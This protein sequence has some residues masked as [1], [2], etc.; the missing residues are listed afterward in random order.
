[1][2]FI[3]GVSNKEHTLYKVVVARDS[4][5]SQVN[6]VY[7]RDTEIA[8]VLVSAIPREVAAWTSSNLELVKRV[9]KFTNGLILASRSETVTTTKVF[10]VEVDE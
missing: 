1:M 10:E 8:S 9:A 6:F 4:H 2:N 7:G 3:E 5:V